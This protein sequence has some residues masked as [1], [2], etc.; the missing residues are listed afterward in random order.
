MKNAANDNLPEGVS[1]IDGA[2]KWIPKVPADIHTIMNLSDPTN[3][4]P[5]IKDGI[6]DPRI[7]RHKLSASNDH[8]EIT[9]PPSDR[10]KIDVPE[11]SRDD[12]MQVGINLLNTSDDATPLEVFLLFEDILKYWLPKIHNFIWV[13]INMSYDGIE[14]A[15]YLDNAWAYLEGNKEAYGPELKLIKIWHQVFV[16]TLNLPEGKSFEA[17]ARMMK[18]LFAKKQAS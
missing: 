5:S 4:H 9:F 10:S 15:C 2:N 17:M 13:D 16:E 1:S 7:V 11:I 3:I 14:S 18:R 6:I 8:Q 12:V